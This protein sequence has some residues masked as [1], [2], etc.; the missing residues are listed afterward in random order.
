MK[1]P[2]C[3][4]YSIVSTCNPTGSPDSE[5]TEFDCDEIGCGFK[6]LLLDRGRTPGQIIELIGDILRAREAHQA[7]QKEPAR[8]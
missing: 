8:D 4:N 5:F 1:C 6:A 7:K 3:D 2:V